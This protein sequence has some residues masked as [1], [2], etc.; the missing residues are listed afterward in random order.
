MLLKKKGGGGVHV[1]MKFSVHDAFHLDWKAK[2][3]K[4][5][6]EPKIKTNKN[7]LMSLMPVIGETG[8]SNLYFLNYTF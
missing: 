2:Y 6:L 7:H 5:L 8:Y 1:D 3:S 4:S